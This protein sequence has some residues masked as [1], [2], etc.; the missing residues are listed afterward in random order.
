MVCN[1]TGSR[2]GQ[3]SVRRTLG[4]VMW[5]VCAE[6]VASPD[7]VSLLRDY[8]AELTVRYFHRE[9]TE[10]EIDETLEEFPSSDLALFLLLRADGAPA[11]CIGLHATGELT[12]M[13][14]A[15]PFRRRG[16]A[17]ALLTATESWARGQGLNRLFLDTRTD[18]VEARAFYASCGFTEIAPPTT[19]PQPF[20][21]HW[22]E[23]PLT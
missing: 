10:Q 3:W 4:P 23:K 21:D 17:R 5:T 12:R 1:R 8:F 9:T 11:G 20:Q 14:V 16:G 15:P 7:A 6:P 19:T 2:L 22:F 13:Y 18:L